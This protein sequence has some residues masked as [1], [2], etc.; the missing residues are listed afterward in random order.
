MT[1]PRP[2]PILGPGPAVR[3]GGAMGGNLPW[4]EAE[5]GPDP[6]SGPGSDPVPSPPAAAGFPPTPSDGPSGEYPF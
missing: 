6:E 2:A 1:R 4:S 5:P 3:V